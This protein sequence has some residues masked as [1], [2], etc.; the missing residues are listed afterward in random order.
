MNAVMNL[1]VP[2]NAMNFLPKDLLASQEG[3]YSI[4]LFS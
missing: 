1:W 2:S 3:L 4:A